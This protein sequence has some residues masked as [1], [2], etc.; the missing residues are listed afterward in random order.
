MNVKGQRSPQYQERCRQQMLSPSPKLG[1][2]IE[3]FFPLHIHPVQVEGETGEETSTSDYTPQIGGESLSQI[4]LR[5]ICNYRGKGELPQSEFFFDK[6]SLLFEM[7]GRILF[8]LAELEPNRGWLESGARFIKTK[9]G[10]DFSLN[11]L[12]DVFFSLERLGKNSPY[13][14]SFVS[15]RDKL[16]SGWW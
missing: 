7:K 8:K 1:R 6:A 5:L 4:Y 14:V 9:N 10:Q 3:T 13:F 15:K 11:S 12:R 2:P 16:L